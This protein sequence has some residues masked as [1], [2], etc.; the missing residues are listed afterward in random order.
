RYTFERGSY[1]VRVSHVVRN[2]GTATWQGALYGQI[3]R[4]GSDDPSTS[5]AGFVPSATFLGAAYWSADKPY[6]KLK[7][8]ALRE[9]P[10]RTVQQGGWIAMVQ[11]YFLTAWLPDR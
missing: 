3:R 5:K 7:F 2:E 6:N 10:L 4:D 11:H 9:E 1:L 8:K